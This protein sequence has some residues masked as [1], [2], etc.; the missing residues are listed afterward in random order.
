MNTSARVQP[1]ATRTELA[2]VLGVGPGMVDALVRTG[3]IPGYRVGKSVRFNVA[4]VLQR[5]RISAESRP[6]A[7][8]KSPEVRT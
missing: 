8:Q 7:A 6:I 1:L 4:E 5:L 3:R 2:E